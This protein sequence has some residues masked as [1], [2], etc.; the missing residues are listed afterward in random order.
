MARPPTSASSRAA[1]R[2]LLDPGL[3]WADVDWLRG[4]Y[5]GPLLLK[6]VLHPDEARQAVEHGMDGVIVSNHG[7]RQLDGAVASFDALPAVV[8]AI[9]GRIP[10]LFDGGI[11]RGSDVVKAL[12]LGATCCLI[13]RPQLWALAVGGEAGVAHML[14]VFYREID[15]VMGLLG[16]SAIGHLRPDCLFRPARKGAIRSAI[17]ADGAQYGVGTMIK[18]PPLLSI[19][20]R[21]ARPAEHGRG[22]VSGACR[23]AFWSTPWAA[24]APSITASARSSPTSAISSGSP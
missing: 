11:R 2:R 18:D 8:E 15:R 6:G 17:A 7:G 22:G 1:C 10:V 13:G 4:L 3:S 24:V 9:A 23:P 19:R 12:A 20:R 14:N 5:D 21:F 16:A